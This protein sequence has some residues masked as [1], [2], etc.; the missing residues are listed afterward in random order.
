M[1]E[2]SDTEPEPG[3]ALFVASGALTAE[4]LLAACSRFLEGSPPRRALV[5]MAAATLAGIA[6]E[7]IRNLALRLTRATDRRRPPRQIALVCGRAVDF[8]LA[9]LLLTHL[10]LEGCPARLAVFM[11][12]GLARAWLSG[13]EAAE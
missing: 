3:L 5:D 7:D 4:E 6:T 8:G 12:Q 10:S 1:V 9:R 11:D 13:G 2:L